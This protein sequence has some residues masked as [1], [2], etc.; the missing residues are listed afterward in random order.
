[1]TIRTAFVITV[2]GAVALAGCT[3]ES[4]VSFDTVAGSEI[5]TDDFGA[6]SRNNAQVMTGQ[7]NTSIDLSRRFAEQAPTTITFAFASA[8]IEPAAAR[9]LDQQA[10]WITN[11]PGVRFRVYGHTDKVGS[12]QANQ[13]LGQQR[14]NAAVAYLVR[15]GIDR[16]RLEGVVS[17]G[18]TQPLVVTD[19]KERR[20]RRTVTEVS[21]FVKGHPLVQDGKYALFSYTETLTSA[22]E[23]HELV[24]IDEQ[25]GAEER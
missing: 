4:R 16:A 12:T 1:M 19:G 10:D 21:G 9:A 3:D 13:R 8:V 18:E 5:D 15:R 7:R 11:Y 2:L 23:P 22:T 20:N 14:A 25:A 24:L 6:S 17:F